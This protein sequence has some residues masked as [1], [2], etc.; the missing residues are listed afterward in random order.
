MWSCLKAL[1][2]AKANAQA[3]AHSQFTRSAHR[4]QLLLL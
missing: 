4:I 1:D 2:S 3:Q